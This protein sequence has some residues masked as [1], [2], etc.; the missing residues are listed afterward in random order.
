MF[1]KL[2][3]SVSKYVFAG[4]YGVKL[5]L[6]AHLFEFLSQ[7]LLLADTGRVV[8]IETYLTKNFGVLG[9]EVGILKQLGIFRN[10]KD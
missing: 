10:R 7:S 2:S 6:E 1:Y 8:K 5:K 3:E 4:L 9:S